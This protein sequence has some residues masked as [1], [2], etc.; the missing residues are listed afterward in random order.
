MILLD[1][2][3]I[4][5]IM[6][7]IYLIVFI[8]LT[9]LWGKMGRNVATSHLIHIIGIFLQWLVFCRIAKKNGNNVS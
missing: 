5:K 2:F 1:Y 9:Y 8:V 6:P 7:F 3:C 4:F